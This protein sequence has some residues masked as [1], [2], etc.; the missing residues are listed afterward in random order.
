MLWEA[1][2]VV[3]TIVREVVDLMVWGALTT[4]SMP[5]TRV[6]QGEGRE[7]KWC[8]NEQGE[9]GLTKGVEAFATWWQWPSYG[10]HLGF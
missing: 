4:T 10:L 3:A 5:I 2:E 9:G 7:G 1:K 6:S 8:F